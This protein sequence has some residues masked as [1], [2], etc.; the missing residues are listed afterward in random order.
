MCT[1]MRRLAL[2]GRP[3][4]LRVVGQGDGLGRDRGDLEGAARE[5][6]G[7]VDGRAGRVPSDLLHDVRRQ[8]LRSWRRKHLPVGEE[9]VEHH[10]HG[11]ALV[12]ARDRRD[13]AV[14]GH[15][16]HRTGGAVAGQSPALLLLPGV[17]EVLGRDRRPVGP[18]GVGVQGVDDR[19]GLG[20][21]QLGL[22]DQV[23]VRA[24][25][26]PARVHHERAGQHGG[27]EQSGARRAPRRRVRIA[28]GRPLAHAEGDRSTRHGHV[29]HRGGGRTRRQP[30]TPRPREGHKPRSSRLSRRHPGPRPRCVTAAEGPK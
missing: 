2:G 14:P 30:R 19:L 15:A 28:P 9:G 8:R 5:V 27:Q 29:G 1:V 23:G 6:N 3:P 13:V 20:A 17:D 26:V 18:D 4:P 22:H 16:G 7:R 11:A 25:V 21:D 24:E 12:A 10:R